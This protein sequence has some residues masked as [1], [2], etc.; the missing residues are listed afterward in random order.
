M[1]SIVFEYDIENQY[2]NSFFTSSLKFIVNI[3]NIQ[4]N[5]SVNVQSMRPLTFTKVQNCNNL[6]PVRRCDLAGYLAVIRYLDETVSI[7]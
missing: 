6:N 1:I 7:K 4:C 5:L 3:M 2:F